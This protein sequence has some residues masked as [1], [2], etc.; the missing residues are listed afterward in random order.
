MEGSAL[1]LERRFC[2]AVCKF[3]RYPYLRDR[4]LSR[5]SLP[6]S[7]KVAT[8]LPHTHTDTTHTD[9]DQ[10]SFQTLVWQSLPRSKPRPSQV[11]SLSSGLVWLSDWSEWGPH[12]IR[13]ENIKT[14]GRWYDNTPFLLPLFYSPFHLPFTF[15][16]CSS[17]CPTP[18]IFRAPSLSH[19]AV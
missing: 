3:G 7:S 8:L 13:G 19:A 5:L 18:L 15:S 9:S 1:C 14:R 16:F 2:L 11:P 6:A 17:F 10:Y 4:F 12:I